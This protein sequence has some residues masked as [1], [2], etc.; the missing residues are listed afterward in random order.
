MPAG[1]PSPKRPG[2][3]ISSDAA[4]KAKKRSTSSGGASTTSRS[5]DT[6]EI[7]PLDI[8]SESLPSWCLQF[9]R[10]DLGLA[11]FAGVRLSTAA[12]RLFET[13]D[14]APAWAALV[15]LQGLAILWGKHS[16]DDSRS[17]RPSDRVTGARKSFERIYRQ[18]LR[19]AQNPVTPSAHRWGPTKQEKKQGRAATIA[20]ELAQI[21]RDYNAAQIPLR[22]IFPEELYSAIKLLTESDAD[23]GYSPS[24]ARATA[25]MRVRR[26]L[27]DDAL[28][29]QLFERYAVLVKT[30][31]KRIAP[32]PGSGSLD[33]QIH[34]YRICEALKAEFGT[35]DDRGE[36]A[37]IAAKFLKVIHDLPKAPTRDQVDKWWARRDEFVFNDKS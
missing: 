7:P 28:I 2:R 34:A 32:Q 21:A 15:A 24:A 37:A 33:L 17:T 25:Q 11:T 5:N 6:A 8:L 23:L 30:P 27:D 18:L 10:H 4:T 1:R 31:H 20:T 12:R 29:A 16:A 19:L 22:V 26:A 36:H 14:A 9:I 3:R 13:K 35:R